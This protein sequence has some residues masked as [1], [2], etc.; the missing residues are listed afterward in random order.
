MVGFIPVGIYHSRNYVEEETKRHEDT[1]QKSEAKIA[2]AIGK[3]GLAMVLAELINE[4][5]RW[6]YL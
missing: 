5:E 2:K 3:H 1:L 6:K 4:R